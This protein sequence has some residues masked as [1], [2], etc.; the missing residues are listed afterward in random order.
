M[1]TPGS[2]V[3]VERID[4]S[5][6][7]A[8]TTRSRLTRPA[9]TLPIVIVVLAAVMAVVLV[10]RGAN[11]PGAGEAIVQV[12]GTARLVRADGSAATVTGSVRLEPKDR[13]ALRTGTATFEL[14][15][16]VRYEG[17]GR[18]G[19]EAGTELEMGLVPTLEAGPLLVTAG[20]GATRL[21]SSSAAARI[22][23]GAIVRLERSY[24]LRLSTYQGRAVVDSA[25]AERGV[26]A[27]HSVDAVGDGELSG[28]APLR[29][30]AGDRWDRRYLANAIYLDGQLAPLRRGIEAANLAP[31]ALVEAVR[32]K[33]ADRPSMASLG[34]MVA[35]R[36]VDADLAIGVAAVGSS[37]GSGDFAGRFDRAFRFHDDGAPWGLVA[38]GLGAD[39]AQVLAALRAGLDTRAIGVAF[40]TG[41]SGSGSTTGSVG[42]L[43]ADG[44]TVAGA[45]V[46]TT[47]RLPGAPGPVEPGDPPAGPGGTAGSVSG[48]PGV[49]GATVPGVPVAPAPGVPGVAVPGVP[50]VTSPPV[51]VPPVRIPP[52][53]L[54]PVALP[55]VL[56]PP[57]GVPLPG[58]S[59]VTVPQVTTPPILRPVLGGVNGTVG[60][61]TGTVNGVTG[62][63]T[64]P[65]R[66]PVGD[67]G[68]LLGR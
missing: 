63:L 65:V 56:V 52:V 45:G 26:P 12:D 57:I 20:A 59:K 8:P 25:G 21:R 55:P 6:G 64:G 68:G 62:G 43:G 66:G 9:V 44:S 58:G 34:R 48:V 13:I 14:A 17:R 35:G 67:L 19:R 31:A 27:L 42:A 61:V 53:T 18:F 49:P 47:P 29:Y 10:H 33:V 60:G 40:A 5:A 41:R 24:A 54:P 15:R 32:S 3:G 30:D 39:P 11:G 51:R 2:S 38:V 50:G 7:V 46:P 16:G 23:A 28:L 37:R 22:D 1:S 4:P 36:T